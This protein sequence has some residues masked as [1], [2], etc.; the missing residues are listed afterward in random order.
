MISKYID[1]FECIKFFEKFIYDNEELFLSDFSK[2]DW[3]QLISVSFGS[4]NVRY[5]YLL[6]DGKTV[7]DAINWNSFFK[8]YEGIKDEDN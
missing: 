1:F 4:E 6:H 2:M 8:W 5:T 7:A 3:F